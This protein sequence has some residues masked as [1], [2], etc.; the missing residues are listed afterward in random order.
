M[1]RHAED[2]G[3]HYL[4]D[5][6]PSGGQIKPE[7]FKVREELFGDQQDLQGRLA[8]E[9]EKCSRITHHLPTF[10]KEYREKQR[11]GRRHQQE[12][13][14]PESVFPHGGAV[15]FVHHEEEDISCHQDQ[16]GEEHFQLRHL[17]G[18]LIRR[19]IHA[20]DVNGHPREGDELE[21]PDEAE[22]QNMM[23]FG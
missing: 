21:I 13:I 12:G 22:E 10:L 8:H 5:R 3:K 11:Q 9:S 17:E 1:E 20:E 18:L 16:K 6:P 2:Q 15:G 23:D 4:Q 19:D 14:P 7:L